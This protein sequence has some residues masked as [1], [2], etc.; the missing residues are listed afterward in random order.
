VDTHLLALKKLGAEIEY[1]RAFKFKAH[2]LTGADIL[3]DETSVTAT[4]NAIMASVLA[5]G[6]NNY[7]QRRQ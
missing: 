3:L 2:G 7:S 1:D 4:E 5:K 6:K